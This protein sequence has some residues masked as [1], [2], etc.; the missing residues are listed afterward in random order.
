MSP[1][2]LCSVLERAPGRDGGE[3]RGPWL[4]PPPRRRPGPQPGLGVSPWRQ[5]GPVP[6]LLTLR[7]APSSLR[8]GP[9]QVSGRCGV[10]RFWT[11]VPLPRPHTLYRPK[12][13]F[14]QDHL[15]L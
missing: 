10:T 4:C 13:C 5:H 2:H 3:M 1:L 12:Y 14:T 9:F 8:I 11:S 7:G 15:G 6:G